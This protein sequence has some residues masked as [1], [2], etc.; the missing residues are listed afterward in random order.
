M[1][2]ALYQRTGQHSIFQLKLEISLTSIHH[3]NMQPMW[4]QCSVA[5]T[6]PCNPTGKYI[7]HIRLWY[8][9]F[10]KNYSWTLEYFAFLWA[11]ILVHF[12]MPEE[13]LGI[14]SVLSG[15]AKLLVHQQQCIIAMQNVYFESVLYCQVTFARWLPWAVIFYHR[16]R[17]RC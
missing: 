14:L 3:V 2:C 7:V 16:L 17:K 12:R 10:L 4:V 13:H 11:E 5:K 1:V 15:T 9:L 6:M 8:A